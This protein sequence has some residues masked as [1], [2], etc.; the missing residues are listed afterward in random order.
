[1]PFAAKTA[2]G[3]RPPRGSASDRGYDGTWRITRRRFLSK[4]RRCLFCGSKSTE[5]DHIDGLGP[6]APLGH[7]PANLRALCKPCHSRRT[8]EAS[9][10][11][12]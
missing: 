4:H 6:R 9:S 12:V 2:S 7:D 8:A 3:F 1:M 10:R 11:W 5:V